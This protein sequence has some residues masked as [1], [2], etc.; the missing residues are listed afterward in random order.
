MPEPKE[1]PPPLLPVLADQLRSATH[2]PPNVLNHIPEQNYNSPKQ[3]NSR[4]K[5][6]NRRSEPNN[7]HSNLRYQ[8]RE[9]PSWK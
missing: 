9:T 2:A 7:S 6:N 1:Q 4:P 5:Q 8:F 3:N